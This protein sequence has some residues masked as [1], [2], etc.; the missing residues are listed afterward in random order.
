VRERATSVARSRRVTPN[1]GLGVAV[2]VAILVAANATSTSWAR[3]QASGVLAEGGPE[4][5]E[6][7]RVGVGFV[8]LVEPRAI[9]GQP[10]EWCDHE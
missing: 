3:P 9:V 10:V 7:E 2:D 1:S 8:D 6:D 4:F 5:F